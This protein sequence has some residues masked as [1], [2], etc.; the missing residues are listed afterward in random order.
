MNNEEYQ[1]AYYDG[2]TAKEW[3]NWAQ[4]LSWV[5]GSAVKVNRNSETDNND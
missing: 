1:K 5:L 2:M 4:K 3:V